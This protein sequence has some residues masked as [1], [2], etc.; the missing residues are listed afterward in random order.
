MNL[1]YEQIK[2][3]ERSLPAYIFDINAF[4]ENI[5]RFRRALGEKIS[6]CYSVKANPWLIGNALKETDSIEVCSA[7]ELEICTALGAESSMIIS[8]GVCRDLGDFV[9][10]LSKGVQ[11]FSIESPRQLALL[12]Q[13]CC[14]LGTTSSVLLRLTNN[15][16]F[17]M[18]VGEAVNLLSNCKGYERISIRGL[19]F[20][21]GTQRLSVDKLN[22]EFSSFLSMLNMLSGFNIE[23]IEYGSGIGAD[24]FRASDEHSLLEAAANH[25]NQLAERY[26]VA[27]ESGRALTADVGVY[28][29]KLVEIKQRDHG[30]FYIVNGGKHQMSYYG[31]PLSAYNPPITCV[32]SHPSEALKAVTI[33]GALCNAGDVLARNI[34]LPMASEGDFIL[35]HRAGAYAVTEG[36]AL[37]LSRELPAVYTIK[38]GEITLRRGLRPTFDLNFNQYA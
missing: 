2:N 37:F 16:H 21:P 34:S 38:N 18:T 26:T 20:Y 30:A 27:F 5:S 7:G 10:A 33:C 24:Y 6:L 19:H 28:V 31:Y 17:G 13:A 9:H 15:N 11:R 23:E 36:T 1:T 3:I 32:C 22:Q 29:T 14:S 12:N 35:F 4:E 25:L 8:G